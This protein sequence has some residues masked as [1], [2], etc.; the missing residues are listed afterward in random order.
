MANMR[1]LTAT[2][3]EVLSEWVSQPTRTGYRNRQLEG[4]M[5]FAGFEQFRADE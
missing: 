5:I 2:K 1:D 3:P 4:T